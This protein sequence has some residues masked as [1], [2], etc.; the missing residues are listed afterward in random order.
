[1]AIM[2]T[3]EGYKEYQSLKNEKR[4]MVNELTERFR[5]KSKCDHCGQQSMDSQPDLGI[6]CD[7]SWCE[8]SMVSLK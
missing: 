7:G 8:G 5:V 4:R 2:I 1:M 3:D 6:M